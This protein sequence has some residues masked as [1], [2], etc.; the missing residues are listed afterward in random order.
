MPFFGILVSHINILIQVITANQPVQ[1]QKQEH[2][3]SFFESYLAVLESTIED[4]LLF[5][6]HRSF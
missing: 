1:Q 3:H 4:P 5:N 2:L 6:T